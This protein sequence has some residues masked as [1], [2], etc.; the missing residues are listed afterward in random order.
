MA[1]AQDADQRVLQLLAAAASGSIP[2]TGLARVASA[3]A[4]WA[5][6]MTG[7][8]REGLKKFFL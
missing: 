3:L 5:E 2:S 4:I 7:A 6:S 8:V 1:L